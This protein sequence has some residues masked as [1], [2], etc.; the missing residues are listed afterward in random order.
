ML[1]ATPW[2]AAQHAVWWDGSPP[3]GNTAKDHSIGYGNGF[4]WQ[5]ALGTATSWDWAHDVIT[6]SSGGYL[7]VGSNGYDDGSHL[8]H[9]DLALYR[10]D[11]EGLLLWEKLY[12]IDNY[13]EM[14]EFKAVEKPDGGFLVAGKLSWGGVGVPRRCILLNCDA[15]GDTLSTRKWT[16]ADMATDDFKL[17]KSPFDESYFISYQRNYSGSYLTDVVKLDYNL[18]TL[19]IIVLP[20]Y[21]FVPKPFGYIYRGGHFDSVFY[22]YLMNFQ[23]EVLDSFPDPFGNFANGMYPMQSLKNGKNIFF[24]LVLQLPRQFKMVTITDSGEV[25]HFNSNCFSGDD[26]WWLNEASD[27]I[28]PREFLDGSICTPFNFYFDYYDYNVTIGLVKLNSRGEHLGD[29]ALTRYD[30]SMWLSKVIEGGDGRVLVFG[31]GENG[32]IGDMDIFIAKLETWNPVS[33]LT[34]NE[35]GTLPLKVYPNPVGQTVTV[36][37][38]QGARGTLSI[39]TLSGLIVHSQPVTANGALTLSA[40]KWPSGLLIVTLTTPNGVYSTK[41]IKN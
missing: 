4:A 19:S 20:N 24:R 33:V 39:V 22:H 5:V 7:V 27:N 21:N 28:T 26:I 36:E 12:A 17:I 23:G 9:A 30:G 11:E 13:K 40:A 10:L 29:T 2:L 15:H 41:L 1:T 25:L 37:L 3:P 16:F 14:N 34:P 6:V 18:D 32:P 8:T 38:P 35:T 31:R